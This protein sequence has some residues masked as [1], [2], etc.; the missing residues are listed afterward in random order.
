MENDIVVPKNVFKG[1]RPI[2]VPPQH[3]LPTFHSAV[4]IFRCQILQVMGF[5]GAKIQVFL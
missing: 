4:T 5:P 1:F 3:Q 2:L